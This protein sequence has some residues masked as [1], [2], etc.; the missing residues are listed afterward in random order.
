M[1]AAAFLVREEEVAVQQGP[2]QKGQGDMGEVLVDDV[3]GFPSP[4]APM[5]VPRFDPAMG[6]GGPAPAPAFHAPCGAQ[7]WTTG[8]GGGRLWWRAHTGVEKRGRGCAHPRGGSWSCVGP[9][10]QTDGA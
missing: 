6:K 3:Q 10:P 8:I 4:K 2:S 1:E 7:G 9:C 5:D